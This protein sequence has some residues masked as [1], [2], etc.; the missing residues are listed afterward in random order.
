MATVE[1]AEQIENQVMM[2]AGRGSLS[3]SVK[4]AEDAQA[5]TFKALHA[6]HDA[7][8]EFNESGKSHGQVSMRTFAES[9]GDRDVIKLGD[10]RVASILSH[11]LDRYGVQFAIDKP[12]KG[13]REFHVHTRDAK[14]LE[15]ALSRAEAR[16]YDDAA[17]LGIKEKVKGALDRMEAPASREAR[18]LHRDLDK[19]A[20][21]L[22]EVEPRG[23]TR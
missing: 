20:P 9:G 2:N 16:V 14:V 21:N 8:K 17:K 10:K 22:D 23:K 5:G 1:N 6:L 13:V 15:T 19:I 3:A 18:E 12:E 4:L 7:V 11:E